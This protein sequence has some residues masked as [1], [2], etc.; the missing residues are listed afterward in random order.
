MVR[1]ARGLRCARCARAG[2]PAP[3]PHPP[4][5][6]PPWPRRCAGQVGPA[7]GGLGRQQQPSGCPPAA[8]GAS[9]HAP[10]PAKCPALLSVVKPVPRACASLRVAVWRTEERGRSRSRPVPRYGWGASVPPARRSGEA[11]R[12]EPTGRDK[13]RLRLS[14]S[15]HRPS[16]A[17][18]PVPDRH[19]I[20]IHTSGS[21][22]FFQKILGCAYV[23]L[24]AEF[25]CCGFSWPMMYF[26][27]F[28]PGVFPPTPLPPAQ[29]KTPLRR[30]SPLVP[31][32]H[33][34]TACFC[35]LEL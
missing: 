7:R 24:L 33:A 28:E 34:R 18:A 31:A 29:F 13:H 10:W 25:L 6:P 26:D 12:L 35:L 22:Y 30:P 23:A 2:P 20:K 5:A 32:L 21:L 1:P 3:P 14:R 17:L 4:P 11:C 19:V 15:L 16:C 9:S 8:A 27:S